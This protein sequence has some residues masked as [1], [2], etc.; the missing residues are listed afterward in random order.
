MPMRSRMID[1]RAGSRH[2]QS[3]RSGSMR[4]V[5]VPAR[6]GT[7]SRVS[8]VFPW[9]GCGSAC[10]TTVDL[11]HYYTAFAAASLDATRR[12]DK[13]ERT[14]L[15]HLAAN[16][17]RHRL[18]AGMTQA[19]LSES[20]GVEPWF[21]RAIEAAREPP[22]FKTLVALARAFDLDVRDL[23]EP[24]PRP[25]RNPGRPKKTPAK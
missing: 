7:C 24:A 3:H 1:L 8:S 17:R 21:I 4:R 6:R 23:F 16:V 15:E 13:T 18:A 11:P 2:Q 10:L 25:V 19:N 14:A 12:V 22:S 20:V 9:A 5:Q